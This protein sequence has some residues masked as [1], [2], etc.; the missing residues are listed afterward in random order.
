MKHVTLTEKS[1]KKVR[2]KFLIKKVFKRLICAVAVF[3]AIIFI[4]KTIYFI[5]VTIYE[6]MIAIAKIT[7]VIEAFS[8]L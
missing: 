2:S 7:K 8:S 6:D 1:L 5:D 4:K 3:S